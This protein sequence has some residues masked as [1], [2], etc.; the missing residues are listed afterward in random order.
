MRSSVPWLCSAAVVLVALVPLG[1]MMKGQFTN[2]QNTGQAFRGAPAHGDQGLSIYSVI[3]NLGYAVVGFHST[4]VMT[5]PGLALAFR[6]CWPV[7]ALL[8][9]HCKPVT[10]L[11]VVMVVVPVVAM[12][13]L[14][15]LKESLADVRYQSTIVPVLLLLIARTVTSLATSRAGARRRRSS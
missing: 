2:A 3:T 9:R 8:G 4:A 15:D 5:R 1:L 6:A 10:Y 11:L 12:F 14:G 13:V 7:V